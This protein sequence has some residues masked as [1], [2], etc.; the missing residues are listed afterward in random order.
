MTGRLGTF[1]LS[2]ISIYPALVI[3]DGEIIQYNSL[4]SYFI[5][6]LN[7]SFSSSVI[8]MIALMQT[9]FANYLVV[10]HKFLENDWS[11]KTL[12]ASEVKASNRDTINNV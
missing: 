10:A 7:F 4:I 8:S 2:L 9:A 5:H 11:M 6:L 12:L 1:A 3:A